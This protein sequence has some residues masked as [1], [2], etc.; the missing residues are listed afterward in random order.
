MARRIVTRDL[1]IAPGRSREAM[2]FLAQLDDQSRRLR[3]DLRGIGPTELGWQAGVRVRAN[4]G[5]GRGTGVNT[6]GMLLAHLA[7][8]EVHWL[9]IATGRQSEERLARVLGIGM[10][11]DG[12]P[13]PRDGPPPAGLRGRGLAY[14]LK[15][16]ARARS[17]TTRIVERLGDRDLDAIAQ[18][19]RRDGLN[20]RASVRWILYHVLEH[21]SGHYGQILLLRHLYRDRRRTSR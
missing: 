15:L 6:I 20:S 8:V 1:A 7:I 3:E 11:D 13:A 4:D 12:M 18:R 2:E 17:H 21:F 16:L 19:T 14:Y 5:S 10:M 9:L